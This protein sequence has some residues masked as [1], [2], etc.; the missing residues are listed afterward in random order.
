MISM[1]NLRKS[2]K[3]L[4]GT[5]LSEIAVMFASIAAGR[6]SPL[7]SVQLLWINLLTDVLPGLALALDPPAADIMKR[8]PSD[9]TKPLLSKAAKLELLVEGG[10]ISAGSL[11][12]FEMAHRLGRTPQESTTSAFVSLTTSQ[13]LHTLSA[14]AEHDGLIKGQFP[15]NKRI[16]GAM[17]FAGATIALG[18]VSPWFRKLLGNAALTP[19]TLGTSLVNGVLPIIALELLK[20]RPGKTELER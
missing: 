2:I 20:L 16:Y 18:V 8:P 13:I 5:N 19:A 6:G 7:N 17:G 11:L 1:A 4:L 10:L 14:S 12:S 15:R 9:P 3:Y